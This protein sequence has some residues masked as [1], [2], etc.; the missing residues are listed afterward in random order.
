MN[1]RELVDEIY[2]KIKKKKYD[3]E[4]EEETDSSTYSQPKDGSASFIL[5]ADIVYSTPTKS[6]GKSSTGSRNESLCYNLPD[7]E[8]KKSIQSTQHQKSSP[9]NE[10]KKKV[11]WIPV[12]YKKRSISCIVYFVL[13]IVTVIGV[14]AYMQ[15]KFAG[16]LQQA[17]F[18]I[19]LSF[20]WFLQNH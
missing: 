4:S 18:Y 15:T 2:E 14:T 11:E 17:T 7:L 1:G 19:E 8:D 10:K 3:L 6:K 5:D 13:L 16:N 20:F 12:Q 9:V